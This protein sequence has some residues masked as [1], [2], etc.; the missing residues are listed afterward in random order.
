MSKGSFFKLLFLFVPAAPRIYLLGNYCYTLHSFSTA[1]KS[2]PGVFFVWPHNFSSLSYVSL[3]FAHRDLEKAF[4]PILRHPM[5]ACAM[6]FEYD[7][8]LFWISGFSPYAY[9]I[10]FP[11]RRNQH[12]S[13]IVEQWKIVQ[14]H[15]FRL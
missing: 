14:N 12:N 10:D 13:P 2:L 6:L 9:R 5:P 3:K 1:H 8:F 4:V 15:L 7:Y 11:P